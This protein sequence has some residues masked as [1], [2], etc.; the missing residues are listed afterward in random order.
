[1]A[2]VFLCEGVKKGEKERNVLNYER[3][4]GGEVEKPMTESYVSLWCE[5]RF[6]YYS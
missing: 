5:E 4:G 6:T 3:R 1:M 2:S